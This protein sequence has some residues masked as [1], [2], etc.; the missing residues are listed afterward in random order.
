LQLVLE[1]LLLHQEKVAQEAHLPLIHYL[2]LVAVAADLLFQ[3]KLQ[4]QMELLVVEEEAKFQVAEALQQVLL[5]DQAIQILLRQVGEIM[6]HQEVLM[7]FPELQ[8]AVA[9]QVESVFK[10][11][12]ETTHLVEQV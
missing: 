9:A 4:E 10:L 3:A 2:F 12:Q 5:E 7:Q 1:V 11:V 8:V 6:V